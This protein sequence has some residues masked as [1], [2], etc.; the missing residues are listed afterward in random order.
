MVKATIEIPEAENRILNILKAIYG[1]KTKGAAI[2]FVIDKY[3]EKVI[4]EKLKPDFV[5][6]MKKIEKEKGISFK[7]IKDLREKIEE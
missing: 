4:E 6:R 1:F 2:R 5:D 3:G 7:N